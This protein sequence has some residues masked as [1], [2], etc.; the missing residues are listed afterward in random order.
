M[1]G[2]AVDQ[3]VFIVF[4]LIC[5][6]AGQAI[7]FPICTPVSGKVFTSVSS[8]KKS[9]LL[10]SFRD[11]MRIA[12]SSGPYRVGFGKAHVFWSKII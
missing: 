4:N 11:L 8:R 12:T 9:C 3:D 7:S 2:F 10:D 5:A 6:G 1:I